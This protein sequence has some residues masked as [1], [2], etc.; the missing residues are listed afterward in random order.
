Q[1]RK[2]MGRSDRASG[3]LSGILNVR[4]PVGM[5]SHDVVDV[6]RLAANTRRVGHAGTLDPA[7]D[8][9]LVVC[10]GKATRVSD[11]LMAGSKTYRATIRFG[12]SSTTDDSEGTITPTAE[13][14]C[15]SGCDL[16][17]ILAQFIGEVDQV[18]PAFAAIKIGGRSLYERARA[19]ET[20]SIPP[21]RVR[22]D[23]IALVDFCDLV[24]VVTVTCSKGTYIRALARDLGR[25]LGTAAY[26]ASLTR[27]RSGSFLVGDS[28]PLETIRRAGGRGYLDRLIYPIDAAVADWPAVVL[29]PP[30]VK[31]VR[32]GGTWKGS[33]GSSAIPRRAYDQVGR[34]VALLSHVPAEA[35]WH[36]T[37]VFLEDQGDDAG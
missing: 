15:L 33:P 12:A 4:K 13:R 17:G 31:I 3:V 5:T 23:D 29:D 20:M 32:H 19:G 28:L 11:L 37:T 8:G 26:L 30:S 9:V 27:T 35:G 21:R 36:P 2:P 14:P 10:V 24:A 22:I 1:P 34:L 16:Q 7:A 25:A 6:V 18:P